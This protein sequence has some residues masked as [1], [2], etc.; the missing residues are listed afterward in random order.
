MV[1]VGLL[2]A[3][4]GAVSPAPTSTPSASPEPAADLPP[5][6]VQHEV[7]WQALAAGDAHPAR[8]LWTYATAAQANS[9]LPSHASIPLSAGSRAYV[10]IVY[11]QFPPDP[12]NHAFTARAFYL[13]MVP[14][15]HSYW[16]LHFLAGRPKL[17]GLGPLHSCIPELPDGSAVWGHTMF[18]GGPPPG[19]PWPLAHMRVGI[20]RGSSASPA[21]PAG[22]PWRKVSS[23]ADGFFTVSLPPGVYTMKLLAKNEGFAA[24]AMVTVTSGQPVAAG[25]YGEGM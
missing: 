4:C 9:L 24:P 11:G 25:V 23:D 21:G 13:V 14:Q 19:G 15:D 8:C 6:W 5:T 20:W 3:G 7:A 12:D 22:Q 10:A 16:A 18:E 17:A 2:L 1:V